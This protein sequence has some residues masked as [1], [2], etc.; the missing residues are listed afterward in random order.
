M[1]IHSFHPSV[2]SQGLKHCIISPISILFDPFDL[3]QN[4]NHKN[5]HIISWFCK[6]QQKQTMSK[7]DVNPRLTRK[8]T[9]SPFL[10]CLLYTLHFMGG[11]F[12][13]SQSLVQ[14]VFGNNEFIGPSL[15]MDH[16]MLL[17]IM[18]LCIT[19]MH[20]R[21]IIQLC[22][23]PEK[24]NTR[25]EMLARKVAQFHANPSSFA[26]SRWQRWR[27]K[28]LRIYFRF[29]GPDGII[30][31][32]G[33]FFE[34][35]LWLRE[36]MEMVSQSS[37]AIE[38][39]NGL[40]HP[41]YS[42]AYAIVLAM[43]C[44]GV[45]LVFSCLTSLSPLKRANIV[46]WM[47]LLS[48]TFYAILLPC[49][50]LA[51]PAIE[52]SND[53]HVVG[54]RTFAL[55][56]LVAFKLFFGS[57]FMSL[58]SSAI[59]LVSMAIMIQTIHENQCDM[60]HGQSTTI[61]ITTLLEDSASQHSDTQCNTD[62]KSVKDAHSLIPVIPNTRSRMTRI[63]KWNQERRLQKIGATLMTFWG[64][65]VL[66]LAIRASLTS[67]CASLSSNG[68]CEIE[69][70]PWFPD[71]DKCHCQAMMLR[72]ENNQHLNRYDTGP[73]QREYL[74]SLFS[75][76]VVDDSVL[77]VLIFDLRLASLPRSFFRLE[78]LVLLEVYE[79]HHLETFGTKSLSEMFPQLMLLTVRAPKMEAIPSTFRSLPPNMRTMVLQIS[80]DELP[81]WM[82]I[83]HLCQCIGK[84]INTIVHD[85]QGSQICQS[86]DIWRKDQSS[87]SLHDKILN[88]C[89]THESIDVKIMNCVGILENQPAQ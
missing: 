19:A 38:I 89:Q 75:N 69:T 7:Q 57:S 54:D 83:G 64:V 39:S 77:M 17:G 56:A 84:M 5:S 70:H 44:I 18:Y 31:R 23:N 25:R 32:R 15:Q 41:G 20:V 16:P 14:F 11:I 78:K 71:G 28:W 50:L 68:I 79:A 74:E 49:S 46:L 36:L 1:E 67:P 2:S 52:I 9:L 4:Q 51:V 10:K 60:R 80:L 6:V 12:A 81:S 63:L 72:F 33:H 8:S 43:N 85:T 76:V 35:K 59:P 48:D 88:L 87:P 24:R 27:Y 45:P 21:G 82:E 13:C 47:D 40:S 30:G 65:T 86:V 26:L 55:K 73:K 61:R 58:L 62:K 22:Q 66:V 29:F 53:I 34:I 3:N 42:L 37:K